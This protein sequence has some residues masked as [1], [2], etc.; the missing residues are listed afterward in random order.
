MKTTARKSIISLT[1]A[2]VFLF[3]SGPV[4]AEI[5]HEQPTDSWYQND[6]VHKGPNVRVFE[7]DN[8]FWGNS[9]TNST[10]TWY[11]GGTPVVVDKMKVEKDTLAGMEQL[12]THEDPTLDWYYNGVSETRNN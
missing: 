5:H 9:H 12:D 8:I 6:P 2:F 11:E 3:L 7:F 1:V 4:V 10:N